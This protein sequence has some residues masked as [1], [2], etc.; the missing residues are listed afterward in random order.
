MN[1]FN[2]FN[3]AYCQNIMAMKIGQSSC[4][5]VFFLLIF[6]VLFRLSYTQTVYQHVSNKS[7]YA[8]I[9]EMANERIIE[10]NSAVKPY[11]RQFIAEKLLE[12]QKSTAS[13]NNRQQKELDFYLK[14]YNKEILPGK[15]WKKRFD[16]FYYKDSLFTFSVNPILG[17]QYW[18]N[19][20]GTNYHRRNGLEMFGYIGKHVGIYASLRDNHEKDLLSGYKY[21]DTRP[22]AVYKSGQDYSEMR[23]G[24][25]FSWKWGT[26]GLIKDHSE[27]GN[28][29]YFPSI[30]SAKAPSVAQLKFSMKPAKWFE[31]NYYHGWLVSGVVDSAG[32]L[33]YSNSYGTSTRRIY[34][35]KYIAA[36]MFTFKPWKGLFTSIGNSIIYSDTDPHPAYLIPFMLFKSADHQNNNASSNEGGQNSQ[37]FIDISSRQIKHLNLYAVLFF[38]DLST[39]RLFKNGHLDYYSL[40]TGFQVSNLVPNTFFT[41]EY[42]QSYPLTYKHNMPVTTYESNFYNMGHY[43]QDNSR[44]FFAEL[45]FRP[46]RGLNI[47]A[48]F[49][50]ARHGKDH[51]E[52]GTNR[53]EVVHLF[54]DSITWKNQRF[55]MDINY[56]LLNDVYLF[57][58]Y[59]YQLN[60][61]EIEKYTAPY[62]RGNT[63]TLSFG[64]NYGF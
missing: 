60:K 62:F 27:W 59:N 21:L 36:N 43:L 4:L 49:Q 58:S 51:E 9:D 31:F 16:L 46:L 54:M 48:S 15:A 28:N 1:K 39:S 24:I 8:F 45:V 50:S 30:V 25:T 7:I 53:K 61:G 26:I 37:F 6:S 17:L 14:D 11:T 18:N 38:D 22:G 42:F 63:S 20:N 3:M 47:S 33:V 2:V 35:K 13:L 23:G 10:L 52:L 56:Q 41:F 29:Y 57:C 55:G 40:N 44:G 19:E 64:V 32:S 34:E 12:V 5:R